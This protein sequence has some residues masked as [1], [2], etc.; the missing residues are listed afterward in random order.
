MGFVGVHECIQALGLQTYSKNGA[1]T[2]ARGRRPIFHNEAVI[3]LYKTDIE[4]MFHDIAEEDLTRERHLPSEESTLLDSDLD[5]VLARLGPEIWPPLATG[6]DRS[7]L[8]KP[9]PDTSYKRDLQYPHDKKMCDPFVRCL[10]LSR[11]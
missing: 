8:R 1:P 2:H 5:E 9:D 7:H 3:Q 4:R 6:A 10:V 11:N